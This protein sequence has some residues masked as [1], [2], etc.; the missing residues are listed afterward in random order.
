VLRKSVGGLGGVSG[1]ALTVVEEGAVA[2]VSFTGLFASLSL[3]SLAIAEAVL[4]SASVSVVGRSSEGGGV[5]IG[6]PTVGGGPARSVDLGSGFG[7]TSGELEMVGRSLDCDL[8]KELCARAVLVGDSDLGVL[9][10]GSLGVLLRDK[11]KSRES[12]RLSMPCPN[13]ALLGDPGLEFA[14]SA[15]LGVISALAR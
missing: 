15:G 11:S 1:F 7:S 14:S 9:S 4:V 13:G 2:N 10:P 5:A 8:E 3:A 12:E 6:S